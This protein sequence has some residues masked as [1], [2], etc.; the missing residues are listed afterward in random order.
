MP[1]NQNVDQNVDNTVGNPV[2]NTNTKQQPVSKFGLQET[3]TVEGVDYTFQF[4]GVKDTIELVDRSKNRF[5]NIVDSLYYQEIMNN[6]IVS[7]KVDWDHWD[8]NNGLREVMA[9]AD[10]FLG[11]QL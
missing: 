4:P 10:N 5:G 9:L 11:R 2:D 8:T 1:E 3:H 7:P 6:V